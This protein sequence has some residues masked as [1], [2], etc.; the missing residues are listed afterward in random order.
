M[1]LLLKTV[2]FSMLLTT[3]VTKYTYYVEVLCMT[4]LKEFN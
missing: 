4:Y 1:V 2:V 3:V